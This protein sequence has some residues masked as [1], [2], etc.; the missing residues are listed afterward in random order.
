MATAHAE[1]QWEEHRHDPIVHTHVHYHVTHNFREMTG[2][3]E[4]LSSQHEHE[5]DHAPL[6]HSHFPHQDFD[7]EHRGEAHIHDHVVPAREK[8]PDGDAT[9]K[10]PR[11]RSAAPR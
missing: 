10:K 7:A 8:L 6:T 9:T 5:H 11:T 3:F 4:H 2:G 1:S